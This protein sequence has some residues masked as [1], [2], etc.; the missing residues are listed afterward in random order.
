MP[1]GGRFAHSVALVMAGLAVLATGAQPAAARPHHHHRNHRPQTAARPGRP[2]APPAPS[3]ATLEAQK[4]E[5]QLVDL[6]VKGAMYPALKVARKIYHL[7]LRTLGP[8]HP[9]TTRALDSV[10]GLAAATGDYA[11]ALRIRKQLLAQ[12]EKQYGVNTF[13]TV[14][15]MQGL[16]GQYW[17]L[18]DFEHADALYRRVLAINKKQFGADSTQYATYLQMY[19]S[20]EWGRHAYAAAEQTFLEAKAILDKAGPG[21][22]GSETGILM[23]L[24]WLYW[25]EGQQVK[26]RRY[27]ERSMADLEKLYE[28]IMP[29]SGMGASMML[30]IASI[31][32]QG[33]RA[34]WAKPLEEKGEKLYRDAVAYIEK[35]KG[36]KDM[37]L[38]TPLS[39]LAQLATRRKQYDEAEK[40]YRRIIDISSAQKNASPLTRVAWLTSLAWLDQ[41]RGRPRDA[42]PLLA[43]VRAA[44]KHSYG[45]YMASTVDQQIASIWQQLGKYDKARRMYEKL[46]RVSRRTWGAHHPLV[47]SQLE[48]LSVVLLAEGRVVQA[49]KH[50]EQAL[51]IEEPHLALV[52]ATGTESDHAIYFGQIAHQLHLAITLNTRYAPKDP[53]AARLALTTVLRRKGRILDAAAGSVAALRKRLSPDDRKLL[54]DLA[55]ARARLAK[56]IVAGPK[57]T[58]SPQDYS[59]EVAKL[60]SEVRRLENLVGQKSAAYRALAQPVDLRSVQ[61]AI[62]GDA[63]LVEMVEYQPYDARAWGSAAVAPSP[64]RYAAYLLHH[65]G[66]PTWVDLGVAADVD[67]AADSFLGA[68]SDPESDDVDAL[69]RALYH[70][71]MAPVARALGQTHKVLVAPDGL[72]NLVP[73]GA[74]VDDSGRHLI[75][76]FTFTY[77]TSGRDL[78]RMKT[79]AA[80]R[81][82]PVIIANP[83]FD[84]GPDADAARAKAGGG[85]SPRPPVSRGVRSRDLRGHKWTPLPGTAR[86]AAALA[87]LLTGAQVLEGSKATEA[88]L[89]KVSGPRILHIA[90]HG[91]F[92]PAEPLPQEDAPPGMGGGGGA[93]AGAAGMS[94]SP[95][96]IFGPPQMA[97]QTGPENPLLRS[98]LA[99]AGAND[100]DS[101]GDDGILTALE[102][103]GLDLWGTQLVVLSACETGVGKVTEG[104]G[105]HGLRRALVIAGARALVMSLW[106]V[107]DSAT[108]KLMTG[109]YKRLEQGEGRSEALRQVQ[110]EMLRSGRYSHPYY[111]AA[112]VPSGDWTPLV[113]AK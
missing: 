32:A 92:L 88:A 71:A 37:S 80:P 68:L 6:Q 57:A 66:D 77:L 79:A 110:L 75:Q 41:T 72:L 63:A 111:W 61:A 8:T 15:A 7:K 103:S 54:D 46:L 16:A 2:S 98:G 48:S 47:G 44:Y 58:A 14:T 11:G 19:G 105:V 53:A 89:K 56:L 52:L 62:P 96:S 30:S 73:F 90:T 74:L 26:A 31:Y 104:D 112:F 84:A 107:D 13:G 35:T 49:R 67:K 99:L 70:K 65:T 20:L 42:L 78:L 83:T 23:N 82:G 9:E 40:L 101:G 45:D 4:L 50:L 91:F 3:R 10:A 33:G 24:G 29:H 76:R 64:R 25:T 43:V 21:Q 36:T 22:S 95:P 69:G 39:S 86:E 106:Q 100:L 55:D 60:E 93:G 28:K 102:A 18:Q 5:K 17:A 1:T 51:D 81:R 108:R 12:A 113:R 59:V 94:S 27:F 38:V 97:D 85:V 34:D 109:Y 87:R